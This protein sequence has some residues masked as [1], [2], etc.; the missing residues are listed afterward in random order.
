MTTQDEQVKAIL[1]AANVTYA[2]EFVPHRLSRNAGKK[3][4]CLNWKI[5]FSRPGVEALYTDFSQGLG[6]VPKIGMGTSPG[7]SAR[8]NRFQRTSEEHAAEHG[9]YML[10]SASEWRRRKL[11]PPSAASV[12]SCLILDA[13]ALAYSFEGWASEFGYDAD[14]REAEA[15]YH[16]CCDNGRALRRIFSRDVL[17]QLREVLQDY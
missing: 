15:V 9:E 8:V 14:S 3:P 4:K 5:S 2:A 12:L 1:A 10:S 6:Y 13:W 17:A 7:S 11:P 16:R